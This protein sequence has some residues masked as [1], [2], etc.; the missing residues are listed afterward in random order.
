MAKMT[1]SEFVKAYYMYAKQTEA[2]TGI[3]ARFTLAQAALET[4]WG[5]SAPGNMFFG[6]KA[7]KD[8]PAD[9]KQLITTREV[10]RSP[11]VRFPEVISITPRSDGRYDYRVKDWFRKYDTPEGSFTDHTQ[12]FFKNQRYAKALEFKMDPYKFAEEIAKAGYATDPNYATSL[13]AVIRTIE[14][15]IEI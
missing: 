10:L 3:D 14:K 9:Q 12:F 11:N 15:H 1:P 8:T 6:V 7:S 2:K 5:K 13:K 4:G